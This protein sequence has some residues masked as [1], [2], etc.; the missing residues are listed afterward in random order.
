MHDTSV[1]HLGEEH[2]D[3]AQAAVNLAVLY[4]SMMLQ[5]LGGAA[6]MTG[7]LLYSMVLHRAVLH[8][9]ILYCSAEYCVCSVYIE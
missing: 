2:Q 6:A 9:N 4:Y 1:G 3:T 5:S 8:C 7:V